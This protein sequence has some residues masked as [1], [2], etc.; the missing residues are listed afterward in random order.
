[1]AASLCRG[2]GPVLRNRGHGR[3]HRLVG[4]PMNAGIAPRVELY[5]T[6]DTTVIKETEQCDG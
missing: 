5:V 6:C 3:T 1:M 2:C 4:A